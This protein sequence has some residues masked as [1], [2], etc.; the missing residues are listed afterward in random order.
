MNATGRI[1][2]K[3]FFALAIALLVVGCNP[4]MRQPLKKSRARLGPETPQK[5]SLLNLPAPKDK[6]VCAVYKFRDQTGQYKPSE[7]GA[8]WSTAVTQGA[9]TILIRA[10]EESDWFVVIERENIGNLLNE[11]KI[12]RSS[13][14]Q[15]MG[16]NGGNQALLPPLLFAGVILEGGI[17]SYET[18]ILTGGAGLRYFGAGAS[19]QYREDR[20]T[21]Y[22]RAVSTSNGKVLKTVYTTKSI[23]SQKVDA[24]LF[25]FVEVK[26]LLEAETGFTYNEPSDLAVTEAI[27]KAVE[28]LIIE[29]V[30]DGLWEL[31]N[32]A[33]TASVALTSY[34]IEKERNFDTDEFGRYIRE[35]QRGDWH[36]G[37]S[38]GV[39]YYDGDYPENELSYTAR[40]N[41]GYNFDK[42]LGLSLNAGLAEF[43][44]NTEFNQQFTFADLNMNY[45][46]L[47]YDNFSPFG[48]LGLG[49]AMESGD[50]EYAT[51]SMIPKVQGGFGFEWMLKPKLGL[52]VS[53]EYN[54]FL[55]DGMDGVKHGKYYD[56]YFAGTLG[57]K[58]YLG[59]NNN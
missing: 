33:D 53:G 41:L 8:N 16:D 48:Y 36:L 39:N 29:G 4:Y 12:I 26:T 37:L 24:N 30:N 44:T 19:G 40:F 52:F 58:F 20:V 55:S 6:I 25:R 14:Q 56:E 27:E 28:S 47:P 42:Y 15:F 54:Y 17:I 35:D 57:V 2:L 45:T 59:K 11:R 49:V 1:T 34:Q 10:L 3:S 43:K 51:E 23:L 18:N 21:I 9:T 50:T 7:T 38:G 5:Q 46:F 32:P 31:A 13:R 22:L